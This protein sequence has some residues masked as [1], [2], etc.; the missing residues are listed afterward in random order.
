MEHPGTTALA[1]AKPRTTRKV[2]LAVHAV[3][4][5]LSITVI[6]LAH[7]SDRREQRQEA[8]KNLGT[9]TASLA[10]QLDARHVDLLL[11]KYR[12]PGLII[13]NTQDARYYVLHDHLRRT[14]DRL[15]LQSP[16]RIVT[17]D[18][19]GAPVEL[20]TSETTP[21]YQMPVPEAA[22]V[23]RSKEGRISAGDVLLASDALRDA[24]GRTVAHVVALH[25]AA[26]ADAR[27]LAALW[28]NLFIAVLLL[29]VSAVVLYRSVGRWLKRDED[30]MG[31]LQARHAGMTDSMAY[32]GKI[33]RALVPRPEAYDAFFDDHFVIDR[34]KDLVSGD[35]H[36]VHRVDEDRCFV[37]AADCT[38]HGLPGAMLATICCSLL[39]EIVPRH[40][41][42]D[43][44]ELLNI[45][46]TRLVTTLHQQGRKQGS[47][48]GMDIALCR[49]DRRTR[50]ILFAGAFRPLYWS[51]GGQV[52]VINGD[53]KPIGG[54]HHDL[55][56][57]FTV[58]RIA[59]SSGDRIYLFSDGYV[60]QFGGPN[61][62]RFMS[63]RLK[64][65]LD[66]HHHLPLDEQARV[67]DQAFDT[68]RGRTEQV[69][70]VCMLGLAV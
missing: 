55:D 42:K 11:E 3:L 54:A 53:R 14:A 36:W 12:E 45:L 46:N 68:W 30:E 70:D 49:V 18:A 15:G 38:G 9:A 27:A 56:R 48:D 5:M 19:Q 10:A 37:A 20:V 50:E 44:A 23:L 2:L 59:Y 43:P 64:T 17:L 31:S 4:L 6:A 63:E 29:A 69:D 67:L 8:L 24:D 47:G 26:E 41:D 60:D 13:K 33:Q 32:A 1:N 52:T 65:L 25:P 62:K 61:G 57:R 28:R 35:F 58:H 39:N 22:N 66:E 40:H 16:L 21:A 7:L 34:P 51:H